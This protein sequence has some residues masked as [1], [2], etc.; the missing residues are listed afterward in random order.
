MVRIQFLT[1][2]DMYLSL[3][4]TN[5]ATEE[6]PIFR[7]TT[8][9]TLKNQTHYCGRAS[10]R[11]IAYDTY[12]FYFCGYKM[13]YDI[14]MNE[15]YACTKNEFITTWE[16]QKVDQGRTYLIRNGFFC[17]T[18]YLGRV[19]MERC[20]EGVD[21]N[22]VVHVIPVDEEMRFFVSDDVSAE[23]RAKSFE[24]R[25][26]DNE[27]VYRDESI[28]YGNENM[29]MPSMGNARALNHSR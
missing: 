25:I 1:D 15:L 5:T 13:C 29:S 23:N 2:L 27:K 11:K 16:L 26:M 18:Y 17:I 22:Q 20:K 12:E 7:A 28:K 10:L 4:I 24:S 8:L 6:L 9:L 21:L 19:R 14:E 3:H